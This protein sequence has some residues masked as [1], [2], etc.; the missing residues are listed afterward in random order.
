MQQP[1]AHLYFVMALEHIESNGHNIAD[2]VRAADALQKV[3]RFCV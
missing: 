2:L 3:R 1:L